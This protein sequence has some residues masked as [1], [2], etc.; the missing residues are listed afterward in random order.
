M[1]PLIGQLCGSLVIVFY[2]FQSVA[3]GMS[4]ACPEYLDTDLSP[5]VAGHL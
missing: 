3:I 1:H 5:P 4:L 2:S